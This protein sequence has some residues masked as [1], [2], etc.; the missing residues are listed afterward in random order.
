MLAVYRE[1]RALNK[2]NPGF[3]LG[4]FIRGCRLSVCK[5][6][7]IT[8]RGAFSSSYIYKDN[9]FMV[10]HHDTTSFYFLSRVIKIK[11]IL[12]LAYSFLILFVSNQSMTVLLFVDKDRTGRNV[13]V[14]C[15]MY[16][17]SHRNCHIWQIC[18][19]DTFQDRA[20]V[21]GQAK[22]SWICIEKFLSWLKYLP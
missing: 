7:V 14:T 16:I 10:T 9:P 15:A 22:I 6:S 17:E 12:P 18:L 2:G 11:S 21:T 1:S 19:A 13:L 5:V 8:D 20:D 4:S 3:L